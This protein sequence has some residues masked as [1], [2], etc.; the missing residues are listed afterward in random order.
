MESNAIRPRLVWAGGLLA[1]TLACCLSCTDGASPPA[2]EIVLESMTGERPPQDR[3]SAAS[4]ERLHS[5]AFHWMSCTTRGNGDPALLAK[6][7]AYDPPLDFTGRFVKARVKVDDPSRLGALELRLTSDDFQSSYFAFGVPLFADSEFNLVK[8][9]VWASL[10]FSL[11]AARIVGTPDR[12]AIDGVGLYFADNGKA[13]VG[14]AWAGLSALD[15]PPEGYLSFTFDD[16]TRSHSE[17]AAPEMA[18][19][20]FRGTA[21]VMPDQ[22]GKT[23]Y[24]TLGEIRE[25]RDRYRWDVAAHHAIPFTEF[26]PAD[27]ESTI[28]GVQRY[29]REQGFGA[30]AVHLAYPLGKQD[31]E[32]VRPLVRKYF[33]TAR[34]AGAGPETL[35]P[36]DPHLL[37]AVNV[38]ETTT[39]EELAEIARRAREHGEWA[40]LMFHHLRESTESQ[41]DYPIERFRRALELIEESGVQVLPVS[42][43]WAL[44]RERETVMAPAKA[45][46]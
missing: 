17:A 15:H 29:L 7:V 19:F 20:G 46:H 1:V 16:G 23:G 2:T 5:A 25:L 27:L 44:A 37:R 11:G 30:G 40:I 45:G 42:E 35:P 28:L 32:R 43:V 34:L 38:L 9:D 12:T 33:A 10:T 4:C 6:P 26:A 14:V 8:N 36:A 41:L 39:A 3:W 21:Y 18:R 24:M 22:I 31:P 13:P